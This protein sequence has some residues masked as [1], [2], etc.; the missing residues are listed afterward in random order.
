MRDRVCQQAA[1]IVL[2][3]I[4]EADFLPCSFGF[5]PKRSATDA[6]EAIRV[7]FP[8]GRQF[9]LEADIQEFFGQIDH[10]RLLSLVAERASDR[11]VLKLLR[12][13]GPRED[14]NLCARIRSPVL[15]H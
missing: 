12:S 2:E 9:V 14:L 7:A 4:F 15:C 5:R 1:R 6:L 13:R 10:A 3:P 11:R 8:R